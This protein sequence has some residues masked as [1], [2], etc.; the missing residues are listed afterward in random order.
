M[1]NSKWFIEIL[2]LFAWV[3]LVTF[4]YANLKENIIPLGGDFSEIVKSHYFWADLSKCGLCALWDGS[5]EGGAPA[6]S[7]A[8]SSKLHPIVA[9]FTLLFGTVKG[10]KL[11]LILIFFLAGLSQWW[12][13]KE[14]NLGSLARVWSGAMAVVAGN[15]SGRMEAADFILV[16]AIVSCS[17][18]FPAIIRLHKVKTVRSAVILGT[19][20]A[21]VVLAG[22]Q[23]LYVGLLMTLPTI[24][25]LLPTKIRELMII[26]KRYAM[27]ALIAVLLSAVFLV[28][29]FHF[30]P[31]FIKGKDKTYIAAQPFKDVLSNLIMS[32]KSFYYRNGFH[33]LPYPS[34]YVNY[35]GWI[36]IVLAFFG[37]LE[38]TNHTRKKFIL[39]LLLSSLL[40]LL[41]ASAYP[42]KIFIRYFPNHWLADFFSMIRYSSVISFLAIAPLIG[43]AAIGVERL[44]NIILKI[45]NPILY[46]LLL[47]VLFYSLESARLFGKS[48]IGTY[49]IDSNIQSLIELLKTPD[50][51]WVS[52]PYGEQIFYE[53]ARGEGLKISDSQRRWG[54]DKRELPKPFLVASRKGGD[55][56]MTY[57]SSYNGV[58]IY[59][60]SDSKYAVVSFQDGGKEACKAYGRGGFIDVHCNLLSSGTLLVK[61]NNWVGWQAEIDGRRLKLGSG[62]W[63]SVNLPAGR[64]IV[65]FRYLPLDVLTGILF[66]ICGII[67]CLWLWFWEQNYKNSK[68]LICI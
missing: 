50:L 8:L 53:P 36:P 19:V 4:P 30:Y 54:W 27:S 61:E 37:V 17:F 65:Q 13:A 33:K 62:N 46:G 51:Q 22:Q 42:M 21:G 64:Q 68:S 67:L 14:L 58:E 29:F 57:K 1:R 47:V 5:V 20:L 59:E 31:N 41:I 16:L 56:N 11:S 52:T 39:Y 12:L 28:P 18:V 55:P 15:L 38:I 25:I 6:V 45:K 24:I 40:P 10:V 48:W 49:R 7:G 26:I 9:V 32:D 63:L 23:Y 3:L 66:T 35:L 34:F 2:L 44:I 60:A 43:L